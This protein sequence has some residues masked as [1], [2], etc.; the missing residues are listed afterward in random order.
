MGIIH[1]NF[2]FIPV[3]L[4]A[5]VLSTGYMLVFAEQGSNI[6][7]IQ[8][9]IE[10][11][12]GTAENSTNEVP[13]IN[14]ALID[15]SSGND[16]TSYTQPSG[17]GLQVSNFSSPQDEGIEEPEQIEEEEFFGQDEYVDEQEFLSRNPLVE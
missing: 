13:L 7:S 11:E 17:S 10:N 16:S 5:I 9:I 1:F 3:S 15:N 8:K 14:E 6:T 2:N 12:T 4:L